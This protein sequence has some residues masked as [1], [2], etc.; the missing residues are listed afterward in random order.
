VPPLAPERLRKKVSSPPA[1]LSVAVAT[2]T[3]FR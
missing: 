1:R 3:V 2:V